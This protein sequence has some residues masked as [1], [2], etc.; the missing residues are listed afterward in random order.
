MLMAIATIT[1]PKRYDRSAWESA[2]LRIGFVVRLVSDAVALMA[3]A[4]RRGDNDL[5]RIGGFLAALCQK[6]FIGGDARLAFRMARFRRG[7]DPFQ[8]A[9]Q[10]FL[11]AG[12]LARF[13]FKAFLLLLQP[14]LGI[15]VIG[16]DG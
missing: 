5:R 8:L 13:L 12:F 6:I 16:L 1:A 11:T 2:I 14:S 4:R 10:R 15:D 9:R 7:A 3:E